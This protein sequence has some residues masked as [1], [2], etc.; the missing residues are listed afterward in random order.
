MRTDRLNVRLG[1]GFTDLW[2]W[3]L[4]DPFPFVQLAIP[5]G[6]I[7]RVYRTSQL[8]CELKDR[9]S[10][11]FGELNVVRLTRCWNNSW[12]KL[13]FEIERLA[14]HNGSGCGF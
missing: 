7:I 10:D 3:D 8:A 5:T 9:L 2:I 11:S 4:S 14:A 13:D 6:V 12:A 1:L